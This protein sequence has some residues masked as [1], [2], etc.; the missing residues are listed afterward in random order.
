VRE[1]ERGR[2]VLA[3]FPDAELVEVASHWKIPELF[4]DPEL[5]PDWLRMKP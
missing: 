1:F 4:A 5:A 2:E 3:R